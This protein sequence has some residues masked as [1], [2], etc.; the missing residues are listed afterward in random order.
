MPTTITFLKPNNDYTTFTAKSFKLG[1]LDTPPEKIS[2]YKLGK[3]F[4]VDTVSVDSLH[5]VHSELINHAVGYARIAGSPITEVLLEAGPHLRNKENFPE[6]ES[7][8]LMLDI[9]GWKVNNPAMWD[10]TD[11]VSTEATIRDLLGTQGFPFLAESEFIFLLTSSQF[12]TATLNCHLYFLLDAPVHIADL[13]EWTTALK[14]V[15]QRTVFDPAT[16]RSVQPDYIGRRKCTDFED[17][18]SEDARVHLCPGLQLAFTDL[19]AQMDKDI[20]SAGWQPGNGNKTKIGSNWLNTLQACGNPDIN[21]PAYR[22]SA[23]MV[24]EFGR[25]QILGNITK[26]AEQMHTEAWKAV[27]ENDPYSNGERDPK[28]D[29][30]TY[31]FTRFQQYLKSACDRKFG[32]TTDAKKDLVLNAIKQAA[33]GDVSLMFDR[34]VLS[35]YGELRKHPGIHASLK[36]EFKKKLRGQVTVTDFERAVKTSRDNQSLDPEHAA[37]FEG[38][39]PSENAYL[40]RVLDSFE[41]LEDGFGSPYVGC[42]SPNG[43]GGYRILQLDSN[44]VNVLYKEG[45]KMSGDTVGDRFGSKA[46]KLLFGKE[47]LDA[48]TT[49]SMFQKAEIGTRI[50]PTGGAYSESK[51][52]WINLGLQPDGKRKCLKVSDEGI[53]TADEKSCPVRWR[54][55]ETMA[56]IILPTT[57]YAGFDSA[58][59]L[60]EWTKIRLFEFFNLRGE[61]KAILLGIIFSMLSGRGT[62]PVVEFVGPASSGKSTAADLLLDLIDPVKG[63]TAAGAGRSNLEAIRK[64]EFVN[65]VSSR[66]L[67]VFDNVSIL[68]RSW[69]DTLCQVATGCS[70][71]NRILYVGSYVKIFAK[72]PIVLTALSSVI[73][74]PDLASRAETLEFTGAGGFKIDTAE[75]F[76]RWEQEKPKLYLGILHLLSEAIINDMDF[77]EEDSSTG[78]EARR[79]WYDLADLV[80]GYN[81]KDRVKNKAD[82]KRV[83][84]KRRDRRRTSNIKL[85]D[86]SDFAKAF[87]AY[88][89][90]LKVNEVIDIPSHIKDAYEEFLN[91]NLGKTLT[92]ETS[93]EPIK[94][95]VRINNGAVTE[96][97]PGFGWML[98]QQ[99]NVILNL[100]G[101]DVNFSKKRTSKGVL[102]TMR[103]VPARD[104]QMEDIL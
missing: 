96:G 41:W 82:K 2:D 95:K 80:F 83:M 23:Q 25:A 99:Y 93:G 92:I 101:W 6:N 48:G 21:E 31:T 69:Q 47:A 10:L 53:E 89:Q 36:A 49:R 32:D 68:S 3:H 104:K 33:D 61:Q 43:D 90:S 5:E 67:S 13:R 64:G 37:E 87:S 11:P 45:L 16:Q 94:W 70:K 79:R 86:Q 44:I 8:L 88:L 103:N 4:D 34:P 66:Y 63:G 1:G 73:T 17:P 29:R 28:K 58:D 38:D 15:R 54:N 50:H 12:T 62:S 98:N 84:Q 65:V 60:K 26:Y 7:C 97:V 40:Q 56:P 57:Q 78:V 91:E 18:I 20:T 27:H 24:Q 30:E 100:T 81:T 59:E 42:P 71:D 22:A 76:S 55:S 35:A 46:L 74:R 52:T 39:A 9:D 19:K 14:Q 77:Q 75:M 85:M 51:E 102:R 72:R